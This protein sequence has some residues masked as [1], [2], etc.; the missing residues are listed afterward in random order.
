MYVSVRPGPVLPESLGLEYRDGL[1]GNIEATKGSELPAWVKSAAK[2]L[3]GGS[4]GQD[5]TALAQRLGQLYAGITKCH[6]LM[7]GER[8][9]Q[10]KLKYIAWKLN[11]LTNIY[12]I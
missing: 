4:E 12:L 11:S 7:I 5:W 10:E 9:L 6:H 2:L 3:N 1:F 8:C